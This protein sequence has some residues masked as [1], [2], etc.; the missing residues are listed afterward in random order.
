MVQVKKDLEKDQKRPKKK[1][2]NTAKEAIKKTAKT[3]VKKVKHTAKTVKTTAQELDRNRVKDILLKE[4]MTKEHKYIILALS[5]ILIAFFIYIGVNFVVQNTA[6]VT[7]VLEEIDLATYERISKQTDKE[8]VYI[9]TKDSEINKE[10][11]DILVDVVRGRKT[12]V[13]FL[14]LG[15]VKERNQIIGFMNTIDLTK[16]TYTEPMLLIFEDGTVKGSL[17]GVSTKK[18]LIAF[19]DKNR[20]D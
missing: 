19:L 14:D 9:A 2:T 10:Y 17:L 16:E 6:T 1:T 11:E 3:T 20:I 4:E 8:I 7:S 18:E 5:S 15:I 13:K 12:K